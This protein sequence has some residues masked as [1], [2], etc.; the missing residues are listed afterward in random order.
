MLNDTAR[1]EQSRFNM[2]EQQVRTWEVLDAKVL[3]LLQKIPREAF[4]PKAYQGLAFADIEI[5]LGHGQTMLAPKIEGRFL[6]ALSLSNQDTVL[7]IG[8]GAGYLTALL[9]KQAKQVDSYEI[10]ASLSNQAKK[11]L[12]A[13]K[14]NHV[15]CM[16]G[17][18]LKLAQG[19]YDAIVLTGSLPVYPQFMERLLKLG[20]RML[21]VVGD[22]PVMQ[23]ILVTR[24]DESSFKQDVLFETCLPVLINAPQPSRFEF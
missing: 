7:E 5:P 8:T 9:A 16:L 4:V 22:A 6:Q 24:V 11:N 17:D 10:Y 14:I 2:V 23:A 13:Q 21:V 3:N 12:A 15:K 20:G 1:V 18:G 19:S